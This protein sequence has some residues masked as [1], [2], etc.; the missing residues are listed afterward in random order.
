MMRSLLG[1]LAERE[2][3]QCGRA[4]PRHLASA[5]VSEVILLVARRRAGSVVALDGGQVL[6]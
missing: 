2:S 3:M 5:K 4:R 1:L 6:L